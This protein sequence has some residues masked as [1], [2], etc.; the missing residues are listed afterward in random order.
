HQISL[1]RRVALKVLPFA[2]ALDGKQLQRFKNEAQAAAGLHHQNIVPVYGVGCERG[3]HYY[4]MQLIDGQT[5]AALIHQS[6][7]PAGLETVVSGQSSVASKESE[8][9]A[10]TTD[11]ASL[12]TG[13][14]SG[15]A[16]FRQAARFGQE[17]AEALEQAHQLGIIH[18][19]VKPANLLVDRRGNIW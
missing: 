4:A 11:N 19:D 10:P 16:Y 12:A 7:Q 5:L 14:N 17:A 1:E 8:P 9:L 15:P 3:I 6:R 18:R 2:A 13:I